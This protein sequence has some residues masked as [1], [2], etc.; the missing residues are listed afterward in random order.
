MSTPSDWMPVFLVQEAHRT[1]NVKLSTVGKVVHHE[2]SH[3]GQSAWARIGTALARPEGGFSIRLNAV[4]LNGS[5]PHA[6]S[7]AGGASRPNP[8]HKIRETDM[9]QHLSLFL[10]FQ[11][12][13][14]TFDLEWDQIQHDSIVLIAAS[15]G[16]E[17]I[18]TAAPE[19]FVGSARYTVNNIAPF[20]GGVSFT[21]TIEWDAPI[22][23]WT[24]VTVFDRSD[25]TT[26]HSVRFPP[27]P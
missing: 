4:P 14:T 10:S 24:T 17:P 20:D 6:P 25:R 5:A 2:M 22:N 7:I 23:L 18:S 26:L 8:D 21:I 11:N 16:K 15:E 13:V 27:P 12:G 1:V 9:P 3:A 19:R